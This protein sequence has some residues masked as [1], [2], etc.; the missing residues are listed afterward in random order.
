LVIVAASGWAFFPTTAEAATAPNYRSYCAR[1]HRGSFVNYMRGTRQ[2]IC[3][4]RRGRYQLMHYRI[5]VGQACRLTTGSAAF[6]RRGWSYVCIGR[7]RVGSG[8]VIRQVRPN[9]SRYC[10][11]YH[12]GSFVNSFRGTGQPICTRRIGRY[13]LRH[14]RINIAEACRLTTGLRAWRRVAVGRYVCLVR[15]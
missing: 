5:N 2:P 13:Q 6:V 14:Y 3:T 10:G 4:I 7:R 12:R 1:Y 15:R 8:G 9:F 11:R